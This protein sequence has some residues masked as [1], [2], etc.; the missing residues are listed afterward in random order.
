ME[1]HVFKKNS[2]TIKYSNI[3]F[4]KFSNEFKS[5]LKKIDKLLDNYN[6]NFSNTRF[7]KT[8]NIFNSLNEQITVDE[9]YRYSE[10]I[11]LLDTLNILNKSNYSKEFSKKIKIIIGGTLLLKDE[12]KTGAR[13]YFFELKM[14]AKFKKSNFLIDFNEESDIQI[15]YNKIK[16]LVECKRPQNEKN[17]VQKAR[18]ARKQ[19]LKHRKYKGIIALDLSKVFYNEIAT[20]HNLIF[21]TYDEIDIIKKLFDNNYH[22][23]INNIKDYD[24]LD[25]VFLIICLLRFSCIV[26][27]PY[28]VVT[29]N[30]YFSINS[31]SNTKEIKDILN[32]L[33]I[34]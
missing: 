27:N 30:H 17:I 11:D 2:T 23:F 34:S 20:E 12:K 6:G 28:E 25:E 33:K 3:D 29:V 9:L 31:Q 14:A 1:Y 15:I 10:A 8:T 32:E 18:D 4:D 7:G 26:L 22:L 13:D 16:Y 24:I 21:N 19:L 5:I